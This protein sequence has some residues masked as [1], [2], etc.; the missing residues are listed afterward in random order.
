[1]LPQATLEQIRQALVDAAAPGP[2]P[3]DPDAYPEGLLDVT[4]L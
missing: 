3:D 2:L 1:M 4:R